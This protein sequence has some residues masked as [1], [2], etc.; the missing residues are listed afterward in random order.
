[1]NTGG[2]ISIIGDRRPVS[3]YREIVFGLTK[4][5]CIAVQDPASYGIPRNFGPW[6]FTDCTFNYSYEGQEG[7]PIMIQVYGGGD[8]VELFV[9]GRSLGVQ[10]CGRETG[11]E[12]QYNT[13]YEPG[14]L[15]AVAYENGAEIGRTSLKTSGKAAKLALGVEKYETLAFIHIDVQDQEGNPSADSAARLS[16]QVDGPAELLAFGGVRALHKKGY[17]LPETT[18]GDGHALAVLKL[19]GEGDIQVSVEGEGLA[20]AAARI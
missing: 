20:G 15:I 2:D 3:Y 18:A 19:T 7:K 11:F 9:N 10:S 6:C 1:M 14:E 16:I 12:T 5:P 4:Q 13:V 8:S 17:E